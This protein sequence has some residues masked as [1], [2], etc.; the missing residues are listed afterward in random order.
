MDQLEHVY[1]GRL[2]YEYPTGQTMVS[3]SKIYN[4]I[5]PVK[6]WLTRETKRK[7]YYASATVLAAEI[8]VSDLVWTNLP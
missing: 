6:S 8:L 5:T 2:T 3:R 4:H 7:T 1:Y